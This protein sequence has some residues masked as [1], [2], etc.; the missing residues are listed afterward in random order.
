MKN[1]STSVSGVTPNSNKQINMF[2]TKLTIAVLFLSLVTI[3]FTS[4][5]NYPDGPLISLVSKTDRVTNNWKIA[6]AFKD[7]VDVTSDY[8]QYELNLSKDGTAKLTAKYVF[9]GANFDFVTNG[10]WTF[11]DDTKKISFNYENDSADGVYQ[12]L[13]LKEDEMWLKEDGGTLELHYV[14]Q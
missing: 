12:I 6:Q 3:G 4:C 11:V 5:D 9:L 1:Q 14:T 7:S 8:N 10:D 13:K 2:K